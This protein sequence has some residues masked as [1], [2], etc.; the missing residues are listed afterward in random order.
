MIL[1]ILC[2]QVT[3]VYVQNQWPTIDWYKY[4]C[5]WER[6]PP[7]MKHVAEILGV[8]E[9]FLAQAVQGRLPERTPAQKETLRIHRR[10]YT[11]LALHD[12][13]HEA[14]IIYV[15]RRYGATK[16]LLQ[17]LQSAAGTFAGMVT[18][19]CNKLGWKNLELLLS[20]FQ[21]RLLFGI[22]RELCDLVKI[23]LLNG[24]RARA[25]YNAGF[26]SLP[27]LATANPLLIENCLRSAVPFKSQKNSGAAGEGT[28]TTWCAKLRQ[29]LSEEK[30]AK[31]IVEEAQKIISSE[32]NLPASAWKRQITVNSELKKQPLKFSGMKFQKSKKIR[33][34][35][36]LGE[37][38]DELSTK[39]Q[40]I[41][42][43]LDNLGTAT[44]SHVITT[45]REPMRPSLPPLITNNVV[46]PVKQPQANTSSQPKSVIATPMDTSAL[47]FIEDSLISFS[48]ILSL[49]PSQSSSI[50][51][52]YKREKLTPRESP[53]PLLIVPDSF[54]D[55]S[56]SFSF[57]TYEK[58][59][60]ACRAEGSTS[61][62]RSPVELVRPH[63]GVEITKST[64]PKT[65]LP[66]STV[67]VAVE[68]IAESPVEIL[69]NDVKLLQGEVS[70]IAESPAACGSDHQTDRAKASLFKTPTR[71]TFG[72]INVTSSPLCLRELSSLCS[73]QLT[74]SG[75]TII[76]ITSNKTLFDTFVSEC[77]EQSS[78]S[79]SVAVMRTDQSNGIGCTI[80][81]M[82]VQ[83]GI[84]LPGGNEQ[85]VGIA[86]CW[87]ELD[88]YYMSLCKSVECVSLDSRNEAITRIFTKSNQEQRLI[89][90]DMKRH[91]KYLAL[92]CGILPARVALDPKVGDWLL[93][94]DQKEKT[95]HRMVLQYLPDQPS[96]S[97]DDDEDQVPLSNLATH[98]SD[99]QIKA[100]AESVLAF[101]LTSK[102]EALLKT[103]GLHKPFIEVEM[104]SLLV[105]AKLELNGIGFSPEEC[106]IVKNA[107]QKRIS[108]LEKEAYTLA[109]H[110]FSLTSPE[111][112]AQVLFIELKLPH[113]GESGKKT[114]GA[115]T[116][117][118]RATNMSTA[119]SILEKI[120]S[121]HPL[122]GI[123]LEWRRISST[124]SNMVFP[125]FKEAV[126]HKDIKSIRIHPKVQVHTATGRVTMSNPS[127]QIVPKEFE[128]GTKLSFTSLQAPSLFSDSQYLEV[129][130]RSTD[131]CED[132][133]PS[134]VSMRNVFV[135]FKG[136]VFL[137]ADYSQLELRILAH[138]SKDKK[139][140]KFLNHDGDVFRLIAS[141]WLG[142]LPDEVGDKQRQETKQI[143]YGMLYGIGAK[144]LGE[145]LGL[146]ENDA[147]QFI[148]SFKMK[149]PAMKRFI[150]ETVQNC[151]ENGYICTLLGRKRYLPG[152]HS[153]NVHARA[154]AERQAVNSSIQ[155]S[156]ADLV[157]TAMIKID[158]VLEDIFPSTVLTSAAR[159]VS[160]GAYFVLQ[161]HDE[162]LYEVA[163]KDLPQ[164]AR[165]V[166]EGME[167][168]ME[169][170]VKFPVKVK[171]GLSWG[172]LDVYNVQ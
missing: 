15:T 167:N 22:E 165:I 46:E 37:I 118:K 170:T 97:E 30:A 140:I 56:F 36:N 2:L 132:K 141:E 26:H 112:V 83:R 156:A 16:G 21:S 78:L 77:L 33:K 17:T 108:E 168:A 53:E 111:D 150:K 102:V 166:K 91:V 85:V 74:Q 86:F 12:L 137:A 28:C 92:T 95:I 157:K 122:P 133:L 121:L 155:G 134:S 63:R 68:T 109:H 67:D 32:L 127:L 144:A 29:G 35:P 39:K 106:T 93:N 172:Q 52:Q 61:L 84:I 138:M 47:H 6:L 120:T 69:A 64:P 57:D 161:L 62:V 153:T 113:G 123:V 87:G 18:V 31:Q 104:P 110:T 43:P 75:V 163:E 149:Y 143:C 136:G 99:P 135:P 119:K 139:L 1:R 41:V 116:R 51:E 5:L 164:V 65:I 71:K 129:C 131:E 100:S 105:L 80:I 38:A 89:A 73:S 27:A 25:L 98:A 54:M 169:L 90:Y 20:Q 72:P 34:S 19:F 125:L 94:P 55:N 66:L 59:D 107:M 124:V 171:S 76:D 126:S 81:E 44:P 8:R 10:F 60:A 24:F 14:P 152:I 96:M 103:E 147:A 151:K 159:T 40:K 130:Q 142:I 79:F 9:S 23:S 158:R 101:L 148:E 4:F 160:S 70:V 3:P 114:L 49:D 50:K 154:Q 58:I 45:A 11:A 13:V 128:I 88:V 42:Q 115:N 82:P 48:P 7:P 146:D 117:R 162:L 145:Q